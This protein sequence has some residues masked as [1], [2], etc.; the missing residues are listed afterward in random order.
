MTCVRLGP[1]FR[2]VL[3]VGIA[4]L[5]GL[6]AASAQVQGIVTEAAQVVQWRDQQGATWPVPAGLVVEV[7][8][9]EDGQYWVLLPPD[10]HGTRRSG[11]IHGNVLQVSLSGFTTLM[12]ATPAPQLPP[13]G[14][15][16]VTGPRPIRAYLQGLGGIT[17][18][19]EF[20]Q[21]FGG[22]LG[23][24][25][26]PA[27]QLSF[28]VGRLHNVLPEE[29]EQTAEAVELDAERFLQQAT[30]QRF[31]VRV[32]ADAPALY[33]LASL[34]VLLRPLGGVR[35]FVLGGL[36]FADLAPDVRFEIS[37]ADVTDQLVGPD[38]FP[39][40]E[41]RVMFTTGGGLSVPLAV[42][43]SVE[44]GYRYSR[45]FLDPGVNVNQGYVGVSYRF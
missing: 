40:E 15:P 26:H 33:G 1:L 41:A 39:D 12:P 43:V 23:F 8:D 32:D 18:E 31:D 22:A 37:D 16:L 9:E 20:S 35:P 4:V 38:A 2:L 27:L 42:P 14:G 7:L 29:T 5:G 13:A 44:F 45:I 11:W 3:F 10:E 21:Q 19:P 30:G 36:G 34:R 28:E 17:F 25:L 6:A 24:E